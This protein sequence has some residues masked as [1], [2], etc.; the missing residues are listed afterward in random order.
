MPLKTGGLVVADGMSSRMGDFKPMLKIGSI[1]IAQRI[2]I[3]LRRA[4]ADPIV[5]V[6]GFNADTL[7]KHLAHMGVVFIRNERYA[8]GKMFD[9]VKIGLEYI[10]NNC[11]RLLFTPVDVP[12]FTLTTVKMLLDDSYRLALPVCE[13]SE[14]HPMLISSALIPSIVNYNGGEGLDGAIKN[15][16]CEKQLVHVK[17]EGIL[18]DKD[19]PEEYTEL[20]HR[21]NEQLFR[22][23]VQFKLAKEVPFFG[24]G[25]A[26]LLNMI[27][28]TGSVKTA[29]QM[30]RLSYSKGWNILRTMEDQ[31]GY[32][33]IKRHKGGIDGGHAQLT[34]EGEELLVKYE[35]F[36]KEALESVQCTFDRIFA[37]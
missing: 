36:E 11:D 8:N 24:T 31:L 21:H 27:K 5:M 1:T 2:I 4:G 26:M 19:T 12:L 16:G 29:C 23:H 15:C 22:L 18:F 9:S 20:L 34:V 30:M 14:G 6:T 3:T 37:V 10:Q 13:G 25:P 32:Q 28:Q 35:Q 17:D 33:V 7:E